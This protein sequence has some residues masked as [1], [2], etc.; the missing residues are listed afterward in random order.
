MDSVLI[1]KLIVAWLTLSYFGTQS[2]IVMFKG[3]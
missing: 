3:A 1:E 2:V